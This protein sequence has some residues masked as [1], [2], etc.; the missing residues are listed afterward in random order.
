MFPKI[1]AAGKIWHAHIFKALRD[2]Y[3]FDINSRWIDLG[4]EGEDPIVTYNKPLLWQ[5]C[6]EDVTAADAVV[7][8]CDDDSEEQRGAV[9]E[10][11]HAMGLLKPVFCINTCKTFSPCAISDVAFTHHPLWN[12][13]RD[14]GRKLS[15]LEGFA[16]AA[17]TIAEASV[18]GRVAMADLKSE[19][20]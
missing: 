7:I 5:M 18:A 14:E 13:V 8:Y 12:W 4:A 19:V 11:G 1:Y 17:R 16:R 10:A 6:L 15:A 2:V 9:M 3:A 20:A